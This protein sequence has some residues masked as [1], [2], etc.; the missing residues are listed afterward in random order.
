M[1]EFK[2]LE[3]GDFTGERALF[4]SKDLK[5]VNSVFHD[6][7]S[8]LKE[9]E[10]LCVEGCSFRWKYP[11]WY[12]DHVVVKNCDFQE[13][14]RAGIWYTNDITLT[15]CE[16]IAPKGFRRAGN[17]KLERVEFSH[18][19]ET[20][21]NCDDVIIK[22]CHVV[23]DYFAMGSRNVLAYNLR[24]DGNYG[25]DS[26]SNIEIHDSIL[27]TKDAFWNCDNVTVYDSTIIGEYLAWNTSNITFINCRIESNQGVCY[28][29][30][31]RMVDCTLE[32]TPLAF[33]YST[34]D[35]TVLSI[36]DSVKNPISGRIVCRGVGE[37]IFD[38]PAIDPSKTEIIIEK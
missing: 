8:P 18:A 1:S 21:W 11:L 28:T 4:M 16:Y 34:C 36:I 13:M 3:N 6:G 23:G 12:C 20:L 27:N 5:V 31:L 30:N 22:D 33:E 15:D 17:I 25:F 26:C 2:L 7:E 38:D 35:A 9:S 32:N 14:G 29:E 24:L 37:L 10:N 19:A